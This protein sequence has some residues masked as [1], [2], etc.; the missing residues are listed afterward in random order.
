MGEMKPEY[1][2]LRWQIWRKL[3]RRGGLQWQRDQGAVT[4]RVT[5]E[6]AARGWRGVG[7]ADRTADQAPKADRVMA[8]VEVKA[9]VPAGSHNESP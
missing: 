2:C 1:R 5:G 7:A 9:R 6:V 8:K 4:D 3:E